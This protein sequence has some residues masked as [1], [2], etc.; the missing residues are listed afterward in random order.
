[1]SDNARDMS[2]IALDRILRMLKQLDA[3]MKEHE[4]ITCFTCSDLL[5]QDSTRRCAEYRHMLETRWKWG[6]RYDDM[7]LAMVLENNN[8]A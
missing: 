2:E 7:T 1:M 3:T 8:N 5:A 4:A 6:K